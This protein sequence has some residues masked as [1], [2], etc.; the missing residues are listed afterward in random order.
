MSTWRLRNC[1][2]GRAIL[3]TSVLGPRSSGWAE[4]FWNHPAR[5][6]TAISHH[7]VEEGCLTLPSVTGAPDGLDSQPMGGGWKNISFEKAPQELTWKAGLG[8][9]L[10]L[11][12]K[13]AILQMKILRSERWCW[14]T[15]QEPVG[16]GLNPGP[17]TPS[18]CP[19]RR[20]PLPASAQAPD[21]VTWSCSWQFSCRAG[22]DTTSTGC[23][24]HTHD[25]LV[26]GVWKPA[27]YTRTWKCRQFIFAWF[28]QWPAGPRQDRL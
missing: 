20:L 16:P 24:E 4:C 28:W 25:T 12:T 15:C 8:P 3:A 26:Q 11:S 13:P 7:N 9:L 14:P 2:D 5:W 1:Q 6:L 17:P 27:N 21:T 19:P 10:R 23:P 18:P 22:S